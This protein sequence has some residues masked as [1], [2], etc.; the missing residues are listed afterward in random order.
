MSPCLCWISAIKACLAFLIILLQLPSSTSVICSA[1][2]ACYSLVYIYVL[3]TILT[4]CATFCHSQQCLWIH[5]VHSMHL[6]EFTTNPTTTDFTRVFPKVTTESHSLP[7]TKIFI[8][9]LFT[10]RPFLSIAV[11]HML[12]HSTTSI[13]G[14]GGFAN[15]SPTVVIDSRMESSSRVR[16]HENRKLYFLFKKGLNWILT[17][18]LTHAEVLKTL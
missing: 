12:K 15:I 11:L 4:A 18:I 9:P 2:N 10:F 17:C 8:F 13:W 1:C 16:Q 14:S 3:H 5:L 7:E 6:T